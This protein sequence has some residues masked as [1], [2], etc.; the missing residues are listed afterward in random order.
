MTDGD[1]KRKER[2]A[3]INKLKIAWRRFY[4]LAVMAGG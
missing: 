4:T 2:N 1:E 3:K